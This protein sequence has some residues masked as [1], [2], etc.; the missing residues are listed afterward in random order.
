MKFAVAAFVLMGLSAALPAAAHC[1]AGPGERMATE[2]G[3]RAVLGFEPKE[4]AV[5]E[6]FRLHLAICD[7]AGRP[8]EGRVAVSAEM[9]AHGHGMD[10]VPSVREDGPGRYMAEGLLLHM[11]GLWRFAVDLHRPDAPPLRFLSDHAQR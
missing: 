2:Q 6:P 11:P 1:V 9:P 3:Y 8:A 10:Y 7:P 5:G 4:P